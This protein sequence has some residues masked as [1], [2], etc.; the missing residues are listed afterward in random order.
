MKKDDSLNQVESKKESRKPYVKP[1]MEQV[2][3]LPEEAV[4]AG[5][6]KTDTSSGPSVP[7]CELGGCIT[8]GS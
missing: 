8:Q 1:R 6:C 3:L 4:L 2:Q 5:G 7:G